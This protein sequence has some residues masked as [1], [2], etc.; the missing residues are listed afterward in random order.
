M[1]KKTFYKTDNK[2]CQ[3]TRHRENMPQPNKGAVI[4]KAFPLRS[5]IKQG[6]PL[7]PHLFNIVL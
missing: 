6:Y 4:I 2:N 5:G 1:Q 3:Q 7:S